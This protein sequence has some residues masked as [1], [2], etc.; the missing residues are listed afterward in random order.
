MVQSTRATNRFQI[1]KLGD[2]ITE[3]RRIE[4]GHAENQ[5]YNL[6]Y[7]YGRSNKVS[8][9]RS[10]PLLDAN[11][12]SD[13]WSDSWLETSQRWP[14]KRKNNLN[15]LWAFWKLI[16]NQ[17]KLCWVKN[18]STN[19]YRDFRHSS[20]CLSF[21]NNNYKR[22]PNTLLLSPSRSIKPHVRSSISLHWNLSINYGPS[23]CAI[24]ETKKQPTNYLH[25]SIYD[26]HH[27]WM[28]SWDFPNRHHDDSH[29]AICP[30]G[31]LADSQGAIA[32]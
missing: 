25:A 1:S 22:L 19:W 21:F 15:L 5:S 27:S 13:Y 29:I 18:L 6:P 17:E 7:S 30:A 16:G 10:F 23:S 28:L 4:T 12:N 20:T 3:P 24:Q 8:F 11:I 9:D 26:T 31:L 2:V 32:F 14:L